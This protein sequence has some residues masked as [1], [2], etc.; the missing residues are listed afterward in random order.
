MSGAS[1]ASIED[2]LNARAKPPTPPRARKKAFVM[3]GAA[4]ALIFAL[5]LVF[6]F[7]IAPKWKE[8][9]RLARQEEAQAERAR[10]GG[11]QPGDLIREAPASYDRLAAASPTA[12]G[13]S[14]LTGAESNGGGEADPQGVERAARPTRSRDAEDAER[15]LSSPL[16]FPQS[17][18]R[19]PLPPAPPAERVTRTEDYAAAYLDRAPLAPL[20]RNELKAGTIIPAAL[21]T[22]I[23]TDLAGSVAARVT[24][25][26]YDTV[27]GEILLVPQGARLLGRYERDVAY[28]QRRAFLVWDRILFPNGVSLSLGAMPA[29]DA[30]GTAGLRDRV[31]YHSGRLLAAI[32]LGAAIT[33]LGELARDSDDD[34]RSLIANAGDAAAAEAAQVTGRLV[35]RELQVRPTIRIRAGAPVRVLLTRDVILD[36]Y[37]EPRP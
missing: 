31:D 9:A 3:L 33:T 12:L 6:G 16:L 7:I 11:A 34:E 37:A 1:K 5:A 21:E 4:A 15:A 27:T 24:S 35:D 14:R 23:D 10:P 19:S 13:D 32:G 28:G 18:R 8:E 29:V 22:A 26:V 36:A 20:S 25:N 2:A 30:A 17:E